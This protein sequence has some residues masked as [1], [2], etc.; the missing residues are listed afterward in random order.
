MQV[1][2]YL[3]LWQLHFEFE[4]SSYGVCHVMNITIVESKSDK[5]LLTH[6][7]NIRE[8]KENA[9][10][11]DKTGQSVQILTKRDS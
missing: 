5:G 11:L 2:C 9:F 10:L 7:Q 4:D 3:T 8:V 6:I 1:Q